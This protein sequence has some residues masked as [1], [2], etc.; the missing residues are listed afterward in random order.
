MH[1]SSIQKNSNYFQRFKLKNQNGRLGGHSYRGSM[2]SINLEI[3]TSRLL[4]EPKATIDLVFYDVAK[5]IYRRQENYIA[6]DVVTNLDGIIEKPNKSKKLNI[7]SLYS[8]VVPL[9]EAGAIFAPGHILVDTIL[10]SCTSS[11]KVIKCG[12]TMPAKKKK[13]HKSK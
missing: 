10:L 7:T 13:C 2:C 12:L 6:W 11:R 1:T 5:N 3:H 9:P 8:Y 4:L